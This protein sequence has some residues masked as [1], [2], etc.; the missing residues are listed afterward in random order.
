LLVN[1]ILIVLVAKAI[2]SA[3]IVIWVYKKSK[4]GFILSFIIS[5]TFTTI[6]LFNLLD[7]SCNNWKNGLKG[8]TLDTSDKYCE[9]REPSICWYDIM[10]GVMDANKIYDCTKQD[11]TY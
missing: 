9:I 6:A 8:E 2:I 1:L 3:E 5:I 10:H 11:K 7:G 4:L